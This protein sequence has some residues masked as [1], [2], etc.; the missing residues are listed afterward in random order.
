[1]KL[2]KVRFFKETYQSTLNEIIFVFFAQNIQKR[3]LVFFCQEKMLN[4]F[5]V[6]MSIIKP[7]VAK[8]M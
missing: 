2:K 8:T 7:T 5:T 1:M 6:Y 3:V 4:I